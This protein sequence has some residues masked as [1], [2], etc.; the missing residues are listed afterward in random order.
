[1]IHTPCPTLHREIR[2][3]LGFA[4]EARRPLEEVSMPAT[5]Q[6]AC[7]RADEL[8]HHNPETPGPGRFEGNDDRILAEMLEELAGDT[9]YLDEEAGDVQAAGW[10]AR[11]GR[12]I[13]EED[14]RGFFA[15]HDGGNELN[16]QAH[17][18]LIA[19]DYVALIASDY[20]D[21]TE[22]EYNL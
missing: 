2:A 15:Y 6:A 10:I 14:E 8:R 22:T 20:E 11:I 18:A 12:F 1:M 7:H 16:A 17:F 9:S 21:A 19:S 13:V 4:D 5:Y 3:Y